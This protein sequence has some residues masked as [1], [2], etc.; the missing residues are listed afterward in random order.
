MISSNPTRSSC[1]PRLSHSVHWI[2]WRVPFIRY[3]PFNGISDY[4][5]CSNCIEISF[6]FLNFII[7][8]FFQHSRALRTTQIHLR[9]WLTKL[10][11]HKQ[12]LS[13][14]KVTYMDS[15][16]HTGISIPL[17]LLMLS[18]WSLLLTA[19]KASLYVEDFEEQ[20]LVSAP[21]GSKIW[22]RYVDDASGQSLLRTVIR[23]LLWKRLL[24]PRNECPQKNLHLKLNL[25]WCYHTWK[26]CQRLFAVAYNDRPYKLFSHSTRHLD[27]T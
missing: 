24:K 7:L 3:G 12:E 14:L 25:L 27:Y 18:W 4:H 10:Q 15:I 9:H 22:K 20:A 8:H 2:W 19:V 13:L 17:S 6:I 23:F 26:A 5:L 11:R 16:L 21:C 1:R